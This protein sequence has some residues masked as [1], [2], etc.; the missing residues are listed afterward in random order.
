MGTAPDHLDEL[1]AMGIDLCTAASNHAYDFGASGVQ[2]TL[3]SMRERQ[4]PV[5]GIGEDLATARSPTYLETPAGRVGLVDA[6]TSVPPG[7]EAGVS[8]AAFD[9]EAGVSPLHIEWTYRVPEAQLDQLRRIAEQTGIEAVK[10]EWLRR[11]NPDWAED[12]AYYFMQMRFAAATEDRL[13]GIYQAVSR[14]D[15]AA[16]LEQVRDASANADWVVLGVHAHQSA[17]GNRNT[18]A[19]PPFL[20][21][22]ARDSVDTG[23]DAVVV[24]GPHTLRGVELYEERPIC[25]SLGNFCFHEEAIYRVPDSPDSVTDESVPDVRGDSASDDAGSDISH[26]ADNWRSVVP[27]CAFAPDGGLSDL[28]LYPLTLRPAADPPRR[29]TPAL[30]TGDTAGSILDTVE[31]RSERFDTTIRR[32]GN[33]GSVEL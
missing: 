26:D 20:R 30:A 5:A 13:P 19:A 32:D 31:R 21:R 14:R 9:G 24:T 25:Y 29:G 1:S 3:S 6:T 12:D 2:C 10:E 4:L 11:E 28:T 22:L 18:S 15:R 16:L 23:A 8:T 27:V 17:D 7:G 33:V